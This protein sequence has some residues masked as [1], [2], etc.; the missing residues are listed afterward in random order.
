ML[1]ESTGRYIIV[2]RWTKDTFIHRFVKLALDAATSYKGGDILLYPSRE[3]RVNCYKKSVHR[4][5]K[6]HARVILYILIVMMQ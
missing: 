6:A 3:P 4:M 5:H 2:G 1:G